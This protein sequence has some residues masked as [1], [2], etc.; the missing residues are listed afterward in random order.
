VTRAAGINAWPVVCSLNQQMVA[1]LQAQGY[2]ANLPLLL[3]ASGALD[4]DILADALQIVLDRHEI[5]RSLFAV[6]G[7]TLMQGAPSPCPADLKFRNL[8]EDEDPVTAAR[9]ACAELCR[10]PFALDTARR[11]V[12][13]AFRLGERDHMIAACADHLAADGMS[14]GTLGMEWRASYQSIEWGVPPQLLMNPPQYRTFSSSGLSRAL[15]ALPRFPA[16]P[17]G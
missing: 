6:V 12:V 13:A 8:A 17:H 1:R 4:L 16:P 11:L 9:A 14:L 2:V 3:R 15:P 5:L 7:S 10:M